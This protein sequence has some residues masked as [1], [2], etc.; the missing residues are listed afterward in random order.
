MTTTHICCD[1][2]GPAVALPSLAGWSR[3]PLPTTQTGTNKG[4]TDF[5]LHFRHRS[6]ADPEETI[7]FAFCFPLAYADHIA[8]NHHQDSSLPRKVPQPAAR[9]FWNT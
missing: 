9:A 6:D 8:R 2:N 1:A 4:D 7:F 5:T 3:L